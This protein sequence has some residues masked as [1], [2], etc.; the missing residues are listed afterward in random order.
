MYHVFLNGPL[1][2]FFAIFIVDQSHENITKRGNIDAHW[3]L[4]GMEVWHK[5]TLI[6]KKLADSIAN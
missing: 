2:G 3:R 1:M 5:K 4:R 6:V